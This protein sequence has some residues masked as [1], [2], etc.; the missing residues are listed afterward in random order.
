MIIT[1]RQNIYDGGVNSVVY[2]VDHINL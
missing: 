1:K 2:N